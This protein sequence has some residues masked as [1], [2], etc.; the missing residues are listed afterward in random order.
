[1]L[2]MVATAHFN[3]ISISVAGTESIIKYENIKPTEMGLVYTAY[4][5]LYTLAMSPG[6]WFID[7][8]GARMALLVVGLGSALF[9]TLTG[10][11][12]LFW[13]GLPLL[14]ALLIIRSMMGV[15]NAPTHPGSARLVGN[16]IP[17]TQQSLVN[18]MVNFAACVGM[19]ITYLLFGELM[20]RFDWTGAS[21]IAGGATLVLAVGWGLFAVDRP[22]AQA[23]DEASISLREGYPSIRPRVP[24]VAL[25]VGALLQSRS[26]I[27]LTVS[28]G[29]LG[30]FQYLF[31]YW[32]Q[33]YF[34]EIRGIENKESRLF[35]SIL[36][37]AM[38]LGMV[39]GGWL[40]DCTRS[41]LSHP[42]TLAIVPVSGLIVSAI[43]LLPGL[44]MNEP[45][46][47]LLCFAVAMTAAGTCEG[48]FWT[49]AV[50]LGGARGGLAAGILNTGG[51]AG[52]LIAPVLTPFIS[53]WL[54]WQ[55]GL[56]VAGVV[57]L[58]GAA[59][60]IGIDP[61][62]RVGERRGESRV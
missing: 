16:L 18:G 1:M 56:G 10:L 30:Y 37:L 5:L 40:T 33:Y 25:S 7:H 41:R 35:T 31:F 6:G 12:G 62:E 43:A 51:N 55:A 50:E 58:F 20:D 3:R 44:F 52:G 60:W 36:T 39:A 19:S 34:E 9:V 24:K 48:A 23:A 8:F 29:A 15:V 54:G 11:A 13:S 46:L 47:T 42:R 38:G 2:A 53:A 26:L 22:V 4:L 21:L 27:L 45:M 17:S 28:Y 59:C 61:H 49:L 14:V 32:A 57:C